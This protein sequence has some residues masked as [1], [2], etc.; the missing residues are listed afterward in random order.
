MRVIIAG[1]GTGG[2]LFPG[3]AIATEFIAKNSKCSIL[4]VGTA[5]PFEKT[6]VGKA[7]FDHKSI[8]AE[9]IK[10]RGFF[11]K[12]RSFIII[13]KGM[14]ES[15]KIIK[16]FNPHIVVGVGGYSAGPVILMAWLL[17]VKTA[18]HEQNIIPGI[19]NRILARFANRIYV[20][21]ERTKLM[22]DSGKTIVAGNPLRREIIDAAKVETITGTGVEKP[23]TVLILGGSQGAHSI[24]MVIGETL[25]HIKAKEKYFFVHQT[26]ASDEK[27]VAG[28]YKQY[29]IP[30]IVKPFFDEMAKLYTQAD[31]II[32][33]AG[34]TTI[35]EV[36]AIGRGVIF[37]PYPFAADD[38]QT[39]NARALS[40]AGA[41]EIIAETDLNG[42]MLAER[43]EYFAG[44]TGELY[45]M[46]SAAKKIS[47]PDAAEII[48]NDCY[49]IVNGK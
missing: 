37:I 45:K 4:F 24:N 31:L 15:F 21:F 7:G 28:F 6:T 43:I 9:G 16:S 41:A 11:K 47:R 39:K 40:D 35:A 22:A 13:P 2:H 44:H 34:A 46:A 1:G 27:S 3:I 10:G 32:C 14:F 25:A 29:G 5:N 36:T 19:T 48:V 42:K 30:C 33:R 8:T 20:S 23:F 49:K 18:L 38:H 26:G 12:M 17:G